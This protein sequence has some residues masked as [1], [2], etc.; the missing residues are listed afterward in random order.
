MIH[1][2]DVFPH[3]LEKLEAPLRN[4]SLIGQNQEKPE[5]GSCLRAQRQKVA[6]L[7]GRPGP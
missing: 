5:W 1:K 7:R 6:E 2:K 4:Y 3:R